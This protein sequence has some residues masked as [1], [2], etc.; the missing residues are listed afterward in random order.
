MTRD[1]RAHDNWSLIQAINLATQRK[2]QVFVVFALRKNLQNHSGTARMLDFMI[3]GLKKVE[4]DLN[5]LGI[6]FDILIGDPV[7]EVRDFA[8]KNDVF[9]IV[10]DQFPL[11]I[12]K[13]WILELSKNNVFGISIVDSHNIVPV[14]EAS[15][16]REFSA[17]TFR[18][19][20]Q[21]QLNYYLTDFPQ[22]MPIST[23]KYPK[24]DW[25][26]IRAN[27]TVEEKIGLPF[28]WSTGADQGFKLLNDFVEF[29]I[30]N[31]TDNKNN[32]N[33]ES[34]SNLSPY[35]HFGQ[36]SAQRVALEIVKKCNPDL[37]NVYLEEL[38]VRR[39]LADNY[40]FYTENYDDFQ[41]LPTWAQ[42]SL[43]KHK[44]DVREHVYT[45]EQFENSQT[46]D[47]MWNAIQNQLK[48]SGKIHGYLRMYWAKKILEWTNTPQD[49]QKIA[50]NLND[51]YSIDGRDPN[52]YTGI[53]WS[54]GGLHDRPWF[55]RPIF[56]QVRYM[57]ISGLKKRGNINEFIKK[58]D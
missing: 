24:I 8:K 10:C 14:W 12:Y 20:I 41:G 22:L 42:N 17:R 18:P 44:L 29:K 56:G 11:K 26:K 2:G 48:Y 28:Q 9:H 30:Q 58:W 36:L 6:N 27:I 19:K 7:A 54:I 40:C 21:H 35:L 37:S 46:H 1:Q 53:A 49:A 5:D 4:K 52:G 45:L 31:Y 25:Q 43:S 34:L 13:N 39:E 57:A 50:I 16:K 51:R 33:L 38:I 23:R 32:F 15:N 55:E 3:L 47:I